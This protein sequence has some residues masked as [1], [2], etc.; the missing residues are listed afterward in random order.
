MP[1]AASRTS[2]GTPCSPV[3]KFRTRMTSVYSVS[4]TRTVVGESGPVNG[5]R[6]ANIAS[7]GMV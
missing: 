3:R 4:P 2:A 1:R 7:D 5:A 6:K